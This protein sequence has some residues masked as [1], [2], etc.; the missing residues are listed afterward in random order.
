M[1]ALGPGACP[2]PPKRR[3]SRN[4]GNGIGMAIFHIVSLAKRVAA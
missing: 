3:E 2:Y 4:A 1:A